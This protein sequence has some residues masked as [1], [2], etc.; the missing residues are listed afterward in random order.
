MVKVL[1]VKIDEKFPFKHGNAKKTFVMLGVC[2]G[3]CVC[4]GSGWS[5][6]KRI[7][8]YDHMSTV[9]VTGSHEVRGQVYIESSGSSQCCPTETLELMKRL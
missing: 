3:V 2:L 7:D 5:R 6:F 1:F 8:G 9:S 4:E